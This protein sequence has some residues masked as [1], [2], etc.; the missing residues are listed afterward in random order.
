MH[1]LHFGT[2]QNPLQQKPSQG[3]RAVQPTAPAVP[4]RS[5]LKLWPPLH[6]LQSHAPLPGPFHS[7]FYIFGVFTLTY[8]YSDAARTDT[9]LTPSQNPTTVSN[10][11]QGD[12]HHSVSEFKYFYG[13]SSSVQ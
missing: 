3:T 10:M 13:F 5:L 8:L 11:I 4:T 6:T 7:E 12:K 9:A 1:V 2:K